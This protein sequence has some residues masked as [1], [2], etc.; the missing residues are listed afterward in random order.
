[1]L[2]EGES[3]RS[4]ED[5]KGHTTCNKVVNFRGGP[6]LAGSLARVRVTEAKAHSLY[7]EFVGVV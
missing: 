1:V 2:V 6:E 5:L 7:G 3:A 4:P